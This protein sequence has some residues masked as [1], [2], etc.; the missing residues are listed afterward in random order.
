MWTDEKLAAELLKDPWGM[1]TSGMLQKH[2]VEPVLNTEQPSTAITCLEHVPTSLS[3]WSEVQV[4]TEGGAFSIDNAVLRKQLSAKLTQISAQKMAAAY[5]EGS[6]ANIMVTLPE[7][8]DA[9][10]N[11][12]K[13]VCFFF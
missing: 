8:H 6:S 2:K 11:T 10:K 9:K 1:I 5:Q 7:C 13:F 3:A 4:N 12:T